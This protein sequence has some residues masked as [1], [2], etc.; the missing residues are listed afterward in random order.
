MPDSSHRQQVRKTLN[1]LTE[2]IAHA[3]VDGM[4]DGSIRTLDPSVAAHLVV[5]GINATAEAHRWI[6]GAS[7]DDAVRLY[8]APLL[9]GLLC[10]T[11]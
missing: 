11:P 10:A 1:Q 4:V 7:A 9:R 5:S 2:R 6:P 8:A 3:V